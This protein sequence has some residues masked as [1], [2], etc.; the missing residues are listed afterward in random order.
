MRDLL[1]HNAVPDNGRIDAGDREGAF[2]PEAANRRV[3]VGQLERRDHQAVAKGKG[4]AVKLAPVFTLWQQPCALPRQAQ[5]CICAK[6]EVSIGI[7][8]MLDRHRQREPGDAG[9]ARFLQDPGHGQF[10][11]IT[12]VADTMPVKGIRV[13]INDAVRLDQPLLQSR[14]QHQRFDGRTGLERIADRPV[15]EIVY[16]RAF[17]VIGV[18]IRVARHGENFPGGDINQHRSP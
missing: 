13:G 14:H 5:P 3:N 16:R 12:H 17:P 11:I 2:K 10:R 4:C 15:A 1:R 18:E 7:N 6:P 9:V 8:Q